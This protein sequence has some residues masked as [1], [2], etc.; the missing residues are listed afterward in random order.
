LQTFLQFKGLKNG[1]AGNFNI[2]GNIFGCNSISGNNSQKI[3]KSEKR[4]TKA[5]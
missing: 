4:R 1:N 3:F 2:G 5:A